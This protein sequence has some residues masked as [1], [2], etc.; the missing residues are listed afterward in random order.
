MKIIILIFLISI[1]SFLSFSQVN[2]EMEATKIIIRCDDIGM[3]HSVNMST[4]QIIEAGIPSS[5][6]VMFTCP[7]YLEAVEIL[8]EHPE[9]SVGIHLTLNSEWKNY[10]WGPVLGKEAVPSLV[11]S[12]GH[13]FTSTQDFLNNNPNLDEVKKEL[14]AQIDRAI[15]TGLHIDFL[16][17]HMM[18]IESSA[19]LRNI[20]LELANEYQLHISNWQGEE[21]KDV[22]MEPYDEKAG[23][24]IEIMQGLN[25]NKTYLFVLH[26]GVDN[27]ELGALIDMNLKDMNYL[28]SKHRNAEREFLLSDDFKNAIKVNNLET[29]TYREFLKDK[30]LSSLKYSEGEDTYI[31]EE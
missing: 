13:F 9:V 5:F 27:D 12:N 21:L 7:W 17:A 29:I 15:G 30:K 10:K 22:F 4:K 14:K 3:C 18:T 11:D 8:K 24:W 1:F 20:L 2:E 16:D 25:H 31:Q 23:K 19:E 26:I 28:V 6:T